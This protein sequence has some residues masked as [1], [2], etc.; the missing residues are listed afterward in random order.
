MFQGYNQQYIELI[1]N[2]L[3]SIKGK[4]NLL[5]DINQGIQSLRV[6]KDS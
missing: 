4:K 6:A 5:A 3:L 2:F 1:D